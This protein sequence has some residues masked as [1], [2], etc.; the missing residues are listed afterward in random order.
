MQQW[1]SQP[2]RWTT[3]KA[4]LQAF[5]GDGGGDIHQAHG[6]GDGAE[7]LAAIVVLFDGVAVD[8]LLAAIVGEQRP[9]GV[10][11]GHLL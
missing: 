5:A 3:A 8:R 10:V 9:H 7:A 11:G 2:P 1:K 6:E 4:R